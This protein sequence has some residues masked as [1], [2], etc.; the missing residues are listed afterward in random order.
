MRLAA[1]VAVADGGVGNGIDIGTRNATYTRT[2]ECPLQRYGSTYMRGMVFD[3]ESLDV[4]DEG[5]GSL[6]VGIKGQDLTIALGGFLDDSFF[7]GAFW[8]HGGISA[9]MLGLDTE[10]VYGVNVYSRNKFKSSQHVNFH[11][12]NQEVR[13]FAVRNGSSGRNKRALWS[14]ILPLKATSLLVGSDDLYL[15]GVRDEVEAEDPWAHF[16][17]RM[18]GLIAICSKRDGQLRRQIELEFPPVFDGMA[19]AIN[20]LVVSCRD[21]SV[22]CFE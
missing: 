10:N 6:R 11:P 9:S 21:G 8:S 18:G 20:K 4:I 19:S 14:S 3:M 1:A 15:A 22:W 7:N 16:D 13:L 5:Q 12:G 17:G 2:Y